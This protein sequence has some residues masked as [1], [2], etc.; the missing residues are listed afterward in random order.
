MN[1]KINREAIKVLKVQFC[2]PP[3]TTFSTLTFFSLAMKPRT[4]KMTK[5]EKKLV[6]QSTHGTKIASLHKKRKKEEK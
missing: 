3:S 4:V 6:I 1:L 5:P 2:L